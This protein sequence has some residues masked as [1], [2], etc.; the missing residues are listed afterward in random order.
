MNQNIRKLEKS[1]LPVLIQWAK[2]ERTLIQWCG[3]VFGFPLTLDQLEEYYS[4]SE[5]PEPPRYLFKYITHESRIVGMC[6]LGNI[7]LRNGSGS[8]CRVFVD[9]E[10]RGKGIAKMLVNEVLKLGFVELNLNRI[11]L[12]VYSYNAGA[13]KCYEELGFV[14]EGVKRSSTKFGDEYWDC[15]IYSILREEWKQV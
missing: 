3:P 8:V 5:Y 1:D 11:D 9:E 10:F 13:I 2:D 14:K 6:E 4:A 15:S 12:N 7:D